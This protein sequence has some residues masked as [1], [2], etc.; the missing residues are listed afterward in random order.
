M[1]FLAFRL[2]QYSLKAGRWE[3]QISPFSVI[4]SPNG[5]IAPASPPRQSQLKQGD[6]SDIYQ[7]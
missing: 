2:Q 7:T 5:L 1:R 4:G 3:L 6:L